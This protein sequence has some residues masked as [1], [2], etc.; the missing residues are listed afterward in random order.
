MWISMVSIRMLQDKA[1]DNIL[2]VP[3]A[4]ADGTVQENRSTNCRHMRFPI[5]LGLFF[6]FLVSSSIFGPAA[7]APVA[8]FSGTPTTGSAPLNVAFADASTG[9][10]TGWVWFFGDEPYTQAWTQMTASAGWAAR[11][12]LSSVVMPDGSIVLMGG[13][14]Y[15][16]AFNKNDVWRSTDNG[17]T[18]TQQTANAGWSARSSHSSVAMPDGSIVLMGGH[19]SISNSLNDVWRST[20]NGATWT[21]QT[22]NAGWSARYSHNSVV[23][24]DGSIVL[25]GGFDSSGHKNDVWRSTDNGATWTQQTAS[26]GWSA[27]YSHNSV[28]MPDGSIVLMGGVDSGNYKNDVWRS[29]NNGAT[30]TQQTASAGWSARYYHRSVAMPDGSIVLMG[31]VNYN[32]APYYKNDVW[33]STD[34]GATWTQVNASAGWS[35]RGLHSS[36]VMSDGSIVLMGGI[37]GVILKN[38][39]WRFQ[40]VGSSL[41]NPSHTY[42][43]PGTYQVALQAYN[44]GGYHSTRKT[45]YI[46]VTSP[47]SPVAAFSGTPTTGSAPLNVAFADASTG[48]PTGWAWFFGDEPYTQAWTLMTAS[49]GWTGRTGCTSVAMPDGSIVLMGGVDDANTNWRKNDV[50]RSINNGA[51]WTQMTAS[52]GWTGRTGHTSVAMPDG[53]IVLMGGVDSGGIKNDVWRSTNSGATWTQQTASAGW[54]GRAY[55][56]SVVMPDGSIVLMGGRDNS[57]T[58]NDVWRSTDYGATWTQQTASAGWSARH[59]HTSVA[60]PDGSIVLMGGLDNGGT[61]DDVWRSTNSGATWTQQTASAGW[62]AR[63][64]HSSVAMPDGSIVLMGGSYG[65]FKNDVWRSINN[66]ATWMQMTA[67]AGWS[68]R[69]GHTSVV[70]LDGSIVLMGGFGDGSKNDVWRFQPVGSSLQTPVHTYTVPGTYQVALQAY[71]TGGYHSTR[72]TGYIAV[73]SPVSPVA[74]FSGTPTTGSAPLNVAFADASTG[75]PTGWAWFFGDEPYTQAWTQM[76]ASAGWTPRY[77]VSYSSVVM[78]DGSIV[79][80]GGEDYNSHYTTKNDVWRS[81]DNGAT[82]TQMTAS[83]GWSARAGHSSVVMVDGSI[84]LLGG[85]DYDINYKND[86]WRSTNNGAMWTQ[87]ASSAGWATRSSHSSVAMPDGSIVLMGGIDG[88]IFPYLKNDV[89]RS[90]DNGA[91]WTQMTASAGWEARCRHSSVT[92]PDNSIVLMGG[93]DNDNKYMNDVWRSTNN[94][95]TWT[96][97]TASA[98]WSARAGHSSV[99]MV[100]GSIV[101]MGGDDGVIGLRN[102]V[103][104][105]TDNGATWTQLTTSA[106]W[107]EESHNSVVMPDGSIVLMGGNSKNEVWRFQPV[108]SSLQSPVHTYTVPGTYKVALQTYNTGGYHS[109]RKTGYITVTTPVT[110]PVVAFSGTPTSGTA[111]LSVQFTDTSSGSPT[112]W[113]WEYNS[114]SGWIEFNTIQNPA[115]SF[116][117]GTYDIRLTATNA[118]GSGTDTKAGYITASPPVT[119][120]VTALSG[121]PTSGTAPFTVQF[122]DTSTGSPTAWKWEYNSGSGWTQ[123][124]TKKNPSK[125]FTTA[126]TYAIRLTA[127]NA[128]GSGT[129]TKTGYITVNPRSNPVPLITS[130]SPSRR[131]HGSSGFILQVTGKKFVNGAKIRWNGALKPT[132]YVSSTSLKATISASNIM[133]KKTASVTVTNPSPGG[134]TSNSKSFVVT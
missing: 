62:S 132:T 22:A 97:M 54:S 63:G 92:M 71:N 16:G 112:A 90:T 86:V 124:N 73:T 66:G 105:S 39:V 99:V 23:M 59:G 56:S 113:K 46:A 6:L 13:E 74:A 5:V 68:A 122:T 96:Q 125:T 43:V 104:R 10:P 133:S 72:K 41:Q 18:W 107:A 119:P 15:N 116:S 85:C 117:A 40:P 3:G 65:S 48:S 17:A 47:V 130:I 64:Y 29:T 27:R 127:T 94:G 36:V 51:T 128:G 32:N 42:T 44:T 88:S 109:T 121:T 100:D 30:W 25:M 11:E 82:W 126:G 91:T 4:G 102:D 98:G 9:T 21:Q 76:T 2:A 89:W 14:D 28:A 103:W 83:A 8:A 101:L 19:Y 131:I 84:V 33:R 79:L 120:P 75:S 106:G 114:G 111:P 70:M 80:M 45:G 108:G 52:A 77:G 7:A 69:H 118:G 49:A 50:W 123:F 38:D 78:P 26:A 110:P 87:V 12:G 93:Y 134:A 60:M 81:T 24:S 20:D 61:K 35:A 34:K 95:A 115:Y 37:D 55:H 31:G 129:D 67:S 58:K 53:S 1:T 57:I